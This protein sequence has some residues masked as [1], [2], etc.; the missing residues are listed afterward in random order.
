MAPKRKRSAAAPTAG[1]ALRSTTPIPVPPIDSAMPPPSVVAAPPQ[2]V[3]RA[4]SRAA[5]KAATN[6]ELNSQ[7]LDGQQALRASPDAEPN[8][9]I[10][11]TPVKREAR[12]ESPLS[13]APANLEPPKKAKRVKKEAA[14]DTEVPAA[15]AGATPATP[16]KKAPAPKKK[17][18]DMG[19][20][21]ESGNDDIEADEEEIKEAS[22]R[23]PPV[24]SDYLP[25]PWK[26]RLGYVSCDSQQQGRIFADYSRLA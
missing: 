24:N 8:E 4:S 2:P 3:R 18:D 5:A 26:G 1:T 12:S 21:P 16:A 25:L 7:V 10:A 17:N 9:K 22:M 13:D 6:P 11:P 20:D 15:T 19:E 23:P 14:A